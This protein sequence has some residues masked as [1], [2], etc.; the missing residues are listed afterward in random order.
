MKAAFVGIWACTVWASLAQG[1]EERPEGR[2]PTNLGS[3]QPPKDLPPPKDL[4]RYHRLVDNGSNATEPQQIHT[5]YGLDPLTSLRFVWS[6]RN[7]TPSEVRWGIAGSPQGSISVGVSSL[8]ISPVQYIHR[9]NLTDLKPGTT[10]NYSVGS[11]AGGWSSPRLIST[12]FESG[13]PQADGFVW[14]IYGDMGLDNEQSLP[15]LISDVQA[16]RIHGVLHVG[17]MAYDL[18]DDDGARGDAWLNSVEPIASVVP[19]HTC[20]GNHESNWGFAQYVARFYMPGPEGSANMFHSFDH[21]NAHIIMLSTEAYFYPTEYGLF[22][23]PKQFEWLEAD[24]QA[25]NAPGQ[26]EKFPWVM[27]G[28]HRPM[29]CSPN[30]DNDDC[31]HI[32]SIVRTGILGMY[33]MEPLLMKYGVDLVIAAHEHSYSRSY[34]FYNYTID[35]SVVSREADGTV[36]YRDPPMPVHVIDGAAGC[37]ENQDPWQPDPS[38][39]DAFHLN[40]YGYGRLAFPNATTAIFEFVD[41]ANGTV[42]DRVVFYQSHHG[43]F[44]A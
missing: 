5:S 21:G 2:F 18:D 1:R 38:F 4:E 6:T 16:S 3:P 15:L 42:V 41:D 26:R 33:A 23:L 8:W 19:Y 37:P 25:A 28:M 29:I 12:A 27:I 35:A 31:H 10:Y 9:V 40:A 13:T 11:D 17:D 44:V 24:L 7:D 14:A 32:D 20:P 22:L 34:P 39:F 30:D 36:V 43:P